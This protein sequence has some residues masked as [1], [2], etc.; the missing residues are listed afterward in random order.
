MLY[1]FKLIDKYI[2]LPTIP[3]LSDEQE[4][5]LFSQL[6]ENPTFQKY[7]DSRERYLIMEHTN[8]FL[9]GKVNNAYGLAGQLLEIRNLRSRVKTV[10]NIM[11]KKRKSLKTGKK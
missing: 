11:D 6:Q 5:G 4:L 2:K 8:Q 1:L 10:Y 7:L 9:A 3:K